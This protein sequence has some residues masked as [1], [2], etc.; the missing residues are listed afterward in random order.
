MKDLNDSDDWEATYDREVAQTRETPLQGNSK[1]KVSFKSNFK[2]QQCLDDDAEPTNDPY[3]E[4]QRRERLQLKAETELLNDLLQGCEMTPADDLLSQ[5]GNNSSDLQ[6]LKNISIVSTQN[7]NSAHF[8]SIA[9]VKK[10]VQSLRPAIEKSPSKSVVWLS[11][12]TGI[13]ELCLPKMET[14]DIKTLISKLENF[15]NTKETSRRVQQESKRKANKG[16]ETRALNYRDEM[17]IFYGA[18]EDSLE[19]ETDDGFM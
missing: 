9:E 3:L 4:R 8:K 17:D 2:K 13:I 16:I 11:F 19:S 12:M 1:P 14:K 5:M 7:L 15:I 10:F 18:N 6:N